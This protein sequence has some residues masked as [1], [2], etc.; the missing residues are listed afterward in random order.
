MSWVSFGCECSSSSARSGLKCTQ[1]ASNSLKSLDS[2][3]AY[4]APHTPSCYL[5]TS[6]AVRF[7]RHLLKSLIKIWGLRDSLTIILTQNK[8]DCPQPQMYPP[9]ALN[10]YTVN[11][12]HKQLQGPTNIFKIDFTLKLSSQQ[13][14]SKIWK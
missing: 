6:L 1:R 8:L 14:V 13:D 2:W 3:G 11:R 12:T 9:V 10:Q 4:S 7:A 5:L